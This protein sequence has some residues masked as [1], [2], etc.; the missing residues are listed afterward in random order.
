M[1]EVDD[2]LVLTNK[3]RILLTI[4]TTSSPKRVKGSAELITP[5][6]VP[7][8]GGAIGG[9]VYPVFHAVKAPLT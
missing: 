5:T 3:D 1:T 4:S 9:C 8:P 6:S 2:R 7:L